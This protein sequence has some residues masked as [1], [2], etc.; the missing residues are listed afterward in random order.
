M[1]GSV[2]SCEMKVFEIPLYVLDWII[3][4]GGKMGI[5]WELTLNVYGLGRMMNSYLTSPLIT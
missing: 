5:G 4:E 1:G 2:L 3:L